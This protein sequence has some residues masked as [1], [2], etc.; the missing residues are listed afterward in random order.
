PVG[1]AEPSELAEGL[2]EELRAEGFTRGLSTRAPAG[3]APDKVLRLA[4]EKVER[5]EKINLD[6]GGAIQLW[7]KHQFRQAAK[8]FERHVKQYPDSPWAGEAL[9]HLG[10]DAKYNGRFSEAQS[11]Y[12]RILEMMGDDEEDGGAGA[13]DGA[14][15]QRRN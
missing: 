6:F 3:S 12:R 15:K 10:C 8:L 14:G 9:L 5:L 13:V 11:R 1:N 4:R 7:N 2:D